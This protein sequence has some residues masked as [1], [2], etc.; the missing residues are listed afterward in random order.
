M[1]IYGT[2]VRIPLPAPEVLSSSRVLGSKST[3][4]ASAKLHLRV[5]RLQPRDSSIL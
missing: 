1:F 2:E 5:D 3:K 4:T